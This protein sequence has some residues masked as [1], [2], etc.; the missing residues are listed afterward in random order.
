MSLLQCGLLRTWEGTIP[1]S[2]SG[3]NLQNLEN[4]VN[5]TC[6]GLAVLIRRNVAGK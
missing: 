2:T 3:A 4:V 6:F 5:L 1:S